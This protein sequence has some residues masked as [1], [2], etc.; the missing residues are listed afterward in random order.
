M[1]TG[2]NSLQVVMSRPVD[3]SKLKMELEGTDAE[4]MLSLSR[5]YSQTVNFRD[6]LSVLISLGQQ[7]ILLFIRMK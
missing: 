5:S 4:N 3:Y 6:F 1:I 7:H 2:N